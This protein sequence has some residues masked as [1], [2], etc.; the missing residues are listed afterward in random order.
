MV[1]WLI[2]RKRIYYVELYLLRYVNHE[3]AWYK[4]VEH[5]SDCRILL[6]CW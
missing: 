1:A 2:F 3:C 6:L 4:H 5:I